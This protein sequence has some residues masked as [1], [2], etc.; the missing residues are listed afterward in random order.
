[1]N[2]LEWYDNRS[3]FPE[4]I[5]DIFYYTPPPPPARKGHPPPLQK[6][7]R[8]LL[9]REALYAYDYDVD[10]GQRRVEEQLASHS[11]VT[12]KFGLSPAYHIL[13]A[14]LLNETMIDVTL[15]RQDGNKQILR[16]LIFERCNIV[17]IKEYNNEVIM[18]F[19]YDFCGDAIRTDK[20]VY[21]M[22]FNYSEYMGTIGPNK[23]FNEYLQQ[24]HLKS[25]NEFHKPSKDHINDTVLRPG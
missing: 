12:I 23:N 2:N 5:M 15:F 4:W 18:V 13:K 3:N 17:S 7:L 8:Y 19:N 22:D 11:A 24:L 21:A 6:P 14:L 16:A 9:K 10:M 1:M 25:L 20:G